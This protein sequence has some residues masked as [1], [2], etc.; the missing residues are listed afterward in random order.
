MCRKTEYTFRL[1]GLSY[2]PSA[3]EAQNTPV[4]AW[5]QNRQ[6][7]FEFLFDLSFSIR[8]YWIYHHQ[9]DFFSF[10]RNEKSLAFTSAERQKTPFLVLNPLNGINYSNDVPIITEN[11]GAFWCYDNTSTE[12]EQE[13]NAA[14]NDLR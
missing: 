3:S 11:D 6:L 10:G 5:K 9:R 2:Y 12:S 13:K 14:H 4:R 7:K 8:V 1:R